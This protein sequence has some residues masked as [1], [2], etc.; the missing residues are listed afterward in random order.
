MSLPTITVKFLQNT[1]VLHNLPIK[2]EIFNTIL[3]SQVHM[4]ARMS[5]TTRFTRVEETRNLGNELENCVRKEMTWQIDTGKAE[6]CNKPSFKRVVSG[7][8]STERTKVR[9]SKYFSY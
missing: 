2:F 6:Q 1:V 4:G 3:K 8:R 5:V 9:I 7:S